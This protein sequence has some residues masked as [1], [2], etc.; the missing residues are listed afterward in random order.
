[1]PYLVIRQKEKGS[2]DLREML[3]GERAWNA[4]GSAGTVTKWYQEIPENIRASFDKDAAINMLQLFVECNENLF[5]AINTDKQTLYHTF[6]IP[7]ASGGKRRIDEPIEDLKRAQRWLKNIFEEDFNTLPHTAAYAYRHGRNVTDVLK[8]HQRTYYRRKTPDDQVKNLTI[9][10]NKD[11]EETGNENNQKMHCLYYLKTDLKDFFPS[12]TE[13]FVFRRLKLIFPFSE[14]MDS[15]K[16]RKIMRQILSLCFLADGGLPQ[17]SPISP[18]LTNLCM[19]GFD[20]A[21]ALYCWKN[22][23]RYTRYADDMLISSRSQINKEEVLNQ[24]RECIRCFCPVYCLND[25]KTK[26]GRNKNGVW[27]LGQMLNGENQ[28][29]IGHEKKKRLKAALTNLVL[30]T[31]NDKPWSS[32]E[33][34][35]LLGLISWYKSVEPEAVDFIVKKIGEKFRANPMALLKA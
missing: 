6:Y 17:G 16:G 1:M 9:E 2:S 11:N 30:D 28:I 4:K 10:D 31:Q 5:N 33:K 8:V 20:R 18:L 24:I 35:H 34:A 15:L 13:E 12:T 29:T 32:A 7:K 26:I 14:I 25:K 27:I 21:M 3:T 23:M 22:N 19:I